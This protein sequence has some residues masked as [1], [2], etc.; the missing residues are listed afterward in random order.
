MII[1]RVMM[2]NQWNHQMTGS[3]DN[4]VIAIKLKRDSHL[5]NHIKAVKT[6]LASAFSTVGLAV[7]AS[8]S[9]HLPTEV[10]LGWYSPALRTQQNV[11]DDSQVQQMWKGEL[12]P[13]STQQ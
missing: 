13:L 4:Q 8:E 12:I 6:E 5:S 2:R 9:W 11:P 10:L 7:K 3:G 1:R